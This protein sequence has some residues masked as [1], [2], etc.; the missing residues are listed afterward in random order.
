MRKKRIVDG[1]RVELVIAKLGSYA[2]YTA[3][4]KPVTL[5]MAESYAAHLARNQC[6]GRIIDN[7][8]GA[9][10]KTWAGKYPAREGQ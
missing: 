5:E 8:T 7:G 3:P 2:P 9:V 6:G 10:V 4:K 1:Y